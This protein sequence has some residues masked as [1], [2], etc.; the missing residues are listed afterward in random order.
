MNGADTAAAEAFIDWM[1]TSDEAKSV[2]EKRGYVQ[3]FAC[4]APKRFGAK[5]RKGDVL[6]ICNFSD[7]L[8]S[9]LEAAQK[10]YRKLYP[11][12]NFENVIKIDPAQFGDTRYG[13]LSGLGAKPRKA[14]AISVEPK[15]DMQQLLRENGWVEPSDYVEVCS[16]TLVLVTTDDQ[17]EDVAGIDDLVDARGVCMVSTRQKTTGSGKYAR[18]VL[19]NAGLIPSADTEHVVQPDFGD[20]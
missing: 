1:R 2:L 8:K 12:V 3:T 17:L 19:Y 13:G 20:N 10:A 15:G 14:C 5:A 6:V 16:D 11:D 4:E 18:Q 7:E 9:M